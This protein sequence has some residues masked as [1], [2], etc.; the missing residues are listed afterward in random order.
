MVYTYKKSVKVFI[1]CLLE[2]QK[3]NNNYVF[4]IFDLAN[5]EGHSQS[6]QQSDA[7]TSEESGV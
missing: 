6:A 4:F 7:V 3:W 2:S 5:I 1:P